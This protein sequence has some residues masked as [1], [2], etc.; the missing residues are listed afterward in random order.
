METIQMN[1]LNISNTDKKIYDEN[2]CQKILQN[3]EN[4]ILASNKAGKHAKSKKFFLFFLVPVL[5]LLI[6][7]LLLLKTLCH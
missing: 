2:D 5:V 6:L 7:I 3:A 4:I 1:K